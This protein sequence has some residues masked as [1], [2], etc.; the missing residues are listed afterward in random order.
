[1]KTWHILRRGTIKDLKWD[2]LPEPSL[3]A[4]F[5]KVRVRGA[6]LNPADLKI[7]SG[8]DGGK[9]IHSSRF[10]AQLGFDFSGLTPSGEEVYGFLPYSP[11]NNQGSFSEFVSVKESEFGRKP[12]NITHAE[13]ASLATVGLT[14]LQA[15]RDSAKIRKGD[16]ILINGASG[17]VG[18]VAIQIAKILGAHVTA[19]ASKEKLDFVKSLGADEVIDYRSK[20]LR[21]IES[22]FDMVFDVAANSSFSVCGKLLNPT[23][24]FLT[25]LPLPSLLAGFVQSLFTGKKVRFIG[26]KSKKADL[27][28]I[29]QWVEAGKLKPVVERQFPLSAVPQALEFLA[30]GKAK[31]K[32]T[33]SME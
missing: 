25:L 33:I 23:G 19:V 7:L 17:G 11:F 30:S 18:T 24:T 14:V 13:A 21:D 16:R 26:V 29:T 20:Q 9:F 4:D 22:K 3:G 5:L 31:G 15:V 10:P 28:L 6:A 8:K 32:L 1:M 12:K 27:D 2:D